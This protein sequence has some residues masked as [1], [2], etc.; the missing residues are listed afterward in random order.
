MSK[1]TNKELLVMQT[2]IRVLVD[3]A[4]KQNLINNKLLETMM[5]MKLAEPD[6][7]SKE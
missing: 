4:E 5:K 6:D 1:L 7:N 2:T 3:L